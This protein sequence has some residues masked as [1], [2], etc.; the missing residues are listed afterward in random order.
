[1]KFHILGTGNFGNMVAHYLRKHNHKV[2]LFLRTPVNFAQFK[3]FQQKITINQPNGD[4]EQTQGYD[5]EVLREFDIDELVERHF[6]YGACP[7]DLQ[8]QRLIVT[9]KAQDVNKSFRK[10][11]YRLS[12]TSTI[13]LL[14]NGMGV[15]EELMEDFFSQDEKLRP[16]ILMGA[17]THIVY[18]TKLVNS[19]FDL[20]HYGI[21]EIDLGIIPR[22]EVESDVTL[23]D[24]DNNEVNNE[25]KDNSDNLKTNSNESNSKIP[26]L[27]ILDINGNELPSIPENSLRTTLEA[28]TSIPELH[29][30][31]V[32][33]LTIQNRL[34]ENLVINACINPL[35][36]IFNIRNGG[37]LFN[38]GADR[39]ISAICKESTQIMQKHREFLGMK[40]SNRFGTERLIDAIYQICKSTVNFKSTMSQDVTT[41]KITEIDYLNGYLVKLGKFYGIPTPVNKLIVDLIYMKHIISS[42]PKNLKRSNII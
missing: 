42:S 35:T 10:I 33:V 22:K 29:C 37:L 19:S 34:L 13:V 17:T 9:T 2:T 7:P 28:L 21:G 32:N 41:R 8:I 38:R 14:T 6:H 20:S 26:K 11:F 5:T 30:R 31:H 25:V 3:K 27:P 12:P 23:N 39:V 1:M 15:Y 16:N 18:R 24:N 4:A 40:P 36:A